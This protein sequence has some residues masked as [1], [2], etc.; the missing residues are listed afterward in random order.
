[1]KK[2]SILGSTGSIGVNTL[3]VIS[4]LGKEYKVV[5]LTAQKNVDLLV[6]QI[7]QFKPEIVALMDEGK[8]RELQRKLLR[9]DYKPL[10]ILFGLS[11]LI[12]VATYPG[13]NFLVS[14]LVGAVG[15][16]PTLEAIKKK[17]TIALANKEILVMAG[18]IIIREALKHK[19][20]IIPLDSEHSAI[21]QCLRG[22]KTEEV[23]KIILTAS[24]GPFYRYPKKNLEK[25]TVSE[26]L[27][28]PNWCMGKKISV[29]SATL[30]NKGLELIE[31]YYLF[32]V[33]IEKIQIVI[34]PQSIIHS[35][36]EFVDGSI[37]AQLGIADMRLPIQF[38]LTYP[39]RQ[40]STR[41]SLKLEKLSSLS[42][43][44]PDF[45]RFPC[46]QLAVKAARKGKSMPT[47]LNAANEVAVDAFLNGKIKFLDIPALIQYVISK[48]KL[49]ENLTLEKILEIDLWTRNKVKEEIK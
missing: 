46:L 44:K 20:K 22:G 14:S 1:M 21:F 42:F 28:H 7:K 10:H 48:H 29:D 36:V 18:E 25:V 8:S 15:L 19:V 26:A 41:A 9:I 5:G 3:R 27:M 45:K 38:A 4:S 6:K 17:K 16:I 31:A 11:G 49:I 24:G 12:N 13:S 33:E 40:E 23:K 35:M 39:Y 2:I 37:I 47:V 43:A 34:H 32:G 30:M